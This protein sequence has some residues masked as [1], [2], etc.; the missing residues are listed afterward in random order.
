MDIL[1]LESGQT[2]GSELLVTSSLV[3]AA[4]LGGGLTSHTGGRRGLLVGSEGSWRT[5]YS[6]GQDRQLGRSCWLPAVSGGSLSWW[7]AADK[8]HRFGEESLW[9]HRLRK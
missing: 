8:L 3:G 7:R 9:Q 6:W 2:S 1:L 4:T 5:F